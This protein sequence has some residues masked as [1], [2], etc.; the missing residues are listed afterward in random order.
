M[1]GDQGTT[2]RYSFD[3]DRDV[4]STRLIRTTDENNSVLTN[5]YQSLANAT[6]NGRNVSFDSAGESVTTLVIN[7]R[8]N[9]IQ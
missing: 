2:E 5:A 7:H 1:Q 3:L 9:L 8:E 4:D 6:V